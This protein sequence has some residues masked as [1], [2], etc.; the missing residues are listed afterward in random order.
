MNAWNSLGSL[1]FLVCSTHRSLSFFFFVLYAFFSVSVGILSILLSDKNFYLY[2][3][4]L[5]RFAIRSLLDIC[6]WNFLMGIKFLGKVVG[7]SVT[8]ICDRTKKE[9]NQTES[10]NNVKPEFRM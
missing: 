2:M 8:P 6:F 9:Q 5:I 10:N 1:W 4:F 3:F 7:W